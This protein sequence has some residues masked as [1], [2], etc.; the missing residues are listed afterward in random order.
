LTELH[1][2]QDRPDTKVIA[3]LLASVPQEEFDVVADIYAGML[4]GHGARIARE[5]HKS[6]GRY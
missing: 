3:R 1:Y 4:H 6:N 2:E 5:I